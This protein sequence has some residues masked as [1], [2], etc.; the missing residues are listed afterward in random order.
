[1]LLEEMLFE[2]SETLIQAW[3]TKRSQSGHGCVLQSPPKLEYNATEG[4]VNKSIS[5]NVS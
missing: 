1:M 5:L 4:M 3:L 2:A